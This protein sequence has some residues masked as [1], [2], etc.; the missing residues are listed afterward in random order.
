VETVVQPR[1]EI[2][3]TEEVAALEDFDLTLDTEPD[4]KTASDAASDLN[5]DLDLDLDLDLALDD[6]PVL[7][8]DLAEP[9]V[10]T[11]SAQS[12]VE[13]DL[14]LQDT[15]DFESLA[16]DDTLELPKSRTARAGMRPVDAASESLED[17]TRSMESSLAGLDLDDDKDADD[18]LDSGDG[19]PDLEFGL[20]DISDELGQGIGQ[21]IND[22]NELDTLAL[23]P[24]DLRRAADAITDRTVAIPR[25][26]DT[27][28]QSVFD[29]TDTKLDLAKAYIELGDADGARAILQEVATDG[30]GDQQAEAQRLLSQLG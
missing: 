1:P 29:E 3:P 10:P 27:E 23:D 21:D 13:F 19:G 4:G 25:D 17:L 14:A 28:F 5:L 9:A 18:G 2:A 16:I 6:G 7:D 22:L 24:E 20:D 30:S 11:T 15:T 12:E 26:P 8:F